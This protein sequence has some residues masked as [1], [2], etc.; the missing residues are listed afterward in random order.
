MDECLGQVAA[1]FAGAPIR[2]FVPLLVRRFVREELQARHGQAELK[3]ESP[4]HMPT[5]ESL[6]AM[7]PRNGPTSHS[8]HYGCHR[9]S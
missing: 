4:L 5:T 3:S 8:R 2:N 9:C 6:S 1:R 7:R